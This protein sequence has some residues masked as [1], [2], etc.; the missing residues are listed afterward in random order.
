MKIIL[1]ILILYLIYGS[2]LA[3]LDFHSNIAN[4][5]LYTLKNPNIKTILYAILIRPTH[6]PYF[7]FAY[8]LKR[9]KRKPVN[10]DAAINKEDK[11]FIFCK[12]N[13]KNWEL[14]ERISNL[15]I[16]GKNIGVVIINKKD[17]TAKI[18]I[19][20]CE[21]PQLIGYY[22]GHIICK[23]IEYK[24]LQTEIN[25]A[26][27]KLDYDQD[28][29]KILNIQINNNR[30][31]I[32]IKCSEIELLDYRQIKIPMDEYRDISTG[33]LWGKYFKIIEQ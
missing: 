26:L 1:Y 3:W 29:Q 12:E 19:I 15:P 16:S 17:K 20:Q 21:K 5:P 25:G 11:Q 4:R 22:E 31:G 13:I 27:F 18:E 28:D 30:Q 6:A 23:N 7:F 10:E 32:V 8:N 33:L 2:F 9:N 24:I 14:L